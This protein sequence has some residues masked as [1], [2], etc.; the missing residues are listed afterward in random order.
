MSAPTMQ[1]IESQDLTLASLFASFYAV[2]SFQREYVWEE[3]QVEQLLGDIYDEFA[4]PERNDSSEYF[5]GS[6]V[7]CA[8]KDGVYDLIDGQQRMTTAYLILC[9]VRDYLQRL[10]TPATIEAL[11]TQISASDVNERGEDVFRYRVTLLYPDSRNVL[12]TIAHG[13]IDVT[14]IKRETRSV[15]N[16]VNAYSVIMAFFREKFGEAAPALRRYYAYFTR[17]VKLIRVRTVSLAHA[18]K[19]FETINDRGVGLD[20]MDLLKN[21][22]FMEAR[23]NDYDR[24]SA[25]W[26]TLVDTL[27]RA[28]EKPLRF[29]RYFIFARYS[30]ERLREED[31]YRWFVENKD[32]CGYT[33]QPLAFVQELLAYARAYVN[34]IAGKDANGHANRY[35]QNLALLC[36]SARQHL[37]LLLAGQHL[38]PELFSELCHQVE[39]LYF[40]YVITRSDTRDFERLFAKWARDVNGI[41]DR[42]ALEGFTRTHFLPAR[43][44]FA[45][46]VDLAMAQLSE[47]SLQ[48]Y[49]LRYVL[50]KLTQYV[51]EQAWGSDGP[52]VLL[53]N[54]I[55]KS[56]EIEHILPQT[57][58][59]VVIA[60][61][62]KPD[63]IPAYIRRLGNLTLVE[64]SINCSVGNGRFTD[65]QTAYRKSNMLLTKSLGEH[66][67]LG[68]NTAVDRASRYLEDFTSWSSSDIDRRQAMLTR[69]AHTVWDIPLARG[70]ES[71]EP[72]ALE[73]GA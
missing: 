60:E 34:F 68:A 42:S 33:A 71:A 40:A 10:P 37:I 53:T 3:E 72:Q 45:A 65:K 27:F 62:D 57:P 54:Y 66:I 1:S 6:I 73:H 8:N 56:V 39:N 12:E 11:N 50:A 24:L 63:E 52:R 30:V 58:S 43:E 55:S 47:Q 29:L 9:A 51:D 18:L 38:T 4:A 70:S 22:M 21:L 35:L 44:A 17:N 49:R 19:V 7:V 64:K 5:I 61:F 28:R 69:L 59:A 23:S 2:P 67:Q 32:L 48:K 16:I 36:G 15:D 41:T 14:H 20:S 25:D 46:R 13:G 26:K 31:I